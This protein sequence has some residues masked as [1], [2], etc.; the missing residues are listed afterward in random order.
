MIIYERLPTALASRSRTL[1]RRRPEARRSAQGRLAR[2]ARALGPSGPFQRAPGAKRYSED[3]LQRAGSAT[4]ARAQLSAAAGPIRTHHA[5]ARSVRAPCLRPSRARTV[6]RT[7]GRV[8][9]EP[10]DPYVVL[11]QRGIGDAPIPIEGTQTPSSAGHRRLN[12]SIP[13]LRSKR[14]AMLHED[15]CALLRPRAWPAFD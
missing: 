6:P 3:G 10:R 4:P 14:K 5:G 13:S 7:V 8:R 1:S 12:D 2:G 9:G 11:H 15:E